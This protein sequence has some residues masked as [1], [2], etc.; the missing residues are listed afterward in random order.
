MEK[1]EVKS[2]Q[3]ILEILGEIKVNR[4]GFK[5]YMSKAAKESAAPEKKESEVKESKVKSK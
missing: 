4:E 1:L 3:F 5:K 2:N